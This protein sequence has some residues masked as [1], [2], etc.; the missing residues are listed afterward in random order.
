MTRIIIENPYEEFI[1]SFPTVK[2]ADEFMHKEYNVTKEERLL[3]NKSGLVK[4]Y[5]MPLA[6]N[7]YI[8]VYSARKDN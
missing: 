7:G 3:P 4:L 6:I 1:A 5:Y 8:E 2:E